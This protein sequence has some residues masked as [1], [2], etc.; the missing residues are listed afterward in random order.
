MRILLIGATGATGATGLETIRQAVERRWDVT[1]LVSDYRVNPRSRPPGGTAI[2]RADAAT[3]M[4]DPV[5]TPTW[6]HATPTLTT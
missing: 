5:L 3:F 2:P 1:A 6:R 4:L